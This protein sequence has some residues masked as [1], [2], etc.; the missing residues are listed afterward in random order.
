MP[1]NSAS[2]AASRTASKLPPI[3][4]IAVASMALILAGGVIFASYLPRQVSMVQI[5]PFVAAAWGLI[6][7][8]LGLLSRLKGYA[9]GTFFRVLRWLLLV[10]LTEA[11]M[12]EFIVVYNH[13]RGRTLVMLTIMLAAFAVNI[14]LLVSY[15]VGRYRSL[16][17]S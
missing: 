3:E 14:P 10:Y 4:A 7:V 11:A 15:F 1:E 13:A 2:S 6:L 12:F 5:V 9:W 17:P 8:N 16:E